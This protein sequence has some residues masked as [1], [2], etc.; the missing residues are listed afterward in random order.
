MV[1]SKR[2]V[3]TL[4]TDQ[5]YA[6]I[7]EAILNGDLPAGARLRVRD[8]AEQVGTSVMPVREAI[9]RLEEAGLAEREPHKGAVVKSL[10]LEEL[11][12]V[13]DVRRLLETEA[14]RLGSQR[15][16]AQDCDKMQAEYEL[17]RS[18]ITERRVIALL[19]HDEAML[20]ILYEAA[21]NPVLVQMI[22]TLW[23]HCRAYK[24]VGA[25]GSLD[26]EGDDSLWRYQQD[27]IAAARKNDADA[28][29]SVNEASLLDASERIKARLAAQSA[30]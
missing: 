7:H 14:A 29:G 4:L 2:V 18:A 6:M 20:S 28:A 25:Q 9:R 10:T 13:Y 3:P 12:H 15:V 30:G 27:L 16:T 26:T 1:I 23:Q 24:I 21:G 17:M 11:I 8:L 5:V 22:R 19:D